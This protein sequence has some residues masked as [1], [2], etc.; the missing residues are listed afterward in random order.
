MSDAEEHITV[1][2]AAERTGLTTRQIHR[3]GETGQLQR[4]KS[5][6]RYLYRLADVQ[7]L[8]DD[9]GV[10]NRPPPDPRPLRPELVPAGELLAYI[11]ERD[12]QLE[13]YQQELVKV[14][15]E[16]AQLRTERAN[17]QLLTT[18]AD[19][20][21]KRYNEVEAERDELRRRV[22]QLERQQRPWWKRLLGN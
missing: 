17:Q 14:A 2:E 5:G 13:Q 9:A 10:A 12:R 6:K 4:R 8:A 11:R 19:L 1:E 20:L 7:R 22:E 18:E 3:Y 21:R 16:V 15:M